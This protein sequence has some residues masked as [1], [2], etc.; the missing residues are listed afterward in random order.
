MCTGAQSLQSVQRQQKEQLGRRH[1]KTASDHRLGRSPEPDTV[2]VGS[3]GLHG[4]AAR[5]I[6][7]AHT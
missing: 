7:L 4:N 1:N 3:P 2:S 6:A 5:A